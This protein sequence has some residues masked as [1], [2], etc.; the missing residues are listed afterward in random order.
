MNP[1]R[2]PLPLVL[3]PHATDDRQ[4]PLPGTTWLPQAPHLGGFGVRR[5]HHIHEG[6]DL[7]APEGTP[8]SAVE[9]GT[10]VRIEPFTGP[11]AGSPWWHDTWAVWVEGATGAVVY[12]EV[13]PEP[14]LRAGQVVAAGARLGEVIPVLRHDKGRPMA[15]LHLELH[16]PGATEAPEWPCAGPRPATLRD[17]TPWLLALVDCP[18]R[19]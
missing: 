8:V 11:H 12:G 1:W 13:R 14:G 16:A 9:A 5:R 19:T 6:V 4:R 17:P 18:N 15:M 3:V 10:V 2:S 7:Y